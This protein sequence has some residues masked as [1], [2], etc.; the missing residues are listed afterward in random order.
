M[1][2]GR[3]RRVPTRRA[4]SASLRAAGAVLLALLLGACALSPHSA[5]DTAPIDAAALPPSDL[6]LDIAGLGPCTDAPDRSLQLS[7]RHPVSI[8]VHGCFGSAG[9]FRSL[10]QVLAFHGQQAACFSYDDRASLMSSSRQ[11]ADAL[12]ALASRLA[13]PQITVIGHSQ[14]GLVAR[15]ALVSERPDPLQSPARFSLVTVSAPF[16]GI[17]AA[18]LCANPLVRIGTLGVND[19]ACWLVSGAKWFEITFASDFIRSPGTLLPAVERHLLVATDEEGSCR[20]RNAAG[21]C[22][23]D[24]FVFSMAEQVLP[25]VTDGVRPQQVSVQA[26]HVEIVG[27]AGVAPAKL[28][29]VLQREGI[30]AP[31]AQSRAGGLQ[32]LLARLYGAPPQHASD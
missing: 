25:E 9:R 18:R 10:A 23:A 30:I 31:T 29:A 5:L 13:A 3:V 26:G 7:S 27:E 20:R 14:G 21:R 32:T 4:A 22:V 1:V 28:I 8:L 15:K 24:D 12:E 19:L 17:R 16:S 6:R 2:E 11:L